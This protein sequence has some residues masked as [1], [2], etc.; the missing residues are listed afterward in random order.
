MLLVIVDDVVELDDV[1]VAILVVD[2]DVIVVLLEVDFVVEMDADVDVDVVGVMVEVDRVGGGTVTV[3]LVGI[4]DCVVVVVR[5]LVVVEVVGTIRVMVDVSVPPRVT[6]PV[7]YV[8][9][10]ILKS[11]GKPIPISMGAPRMDVFAI[12]KQPRSSREVRCTIARGF[13]VESI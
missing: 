3:D 4:D 8:K 9:P 6:P 11:V 10:G 2:I 1:D 12:E 7:G 5:G 13:D